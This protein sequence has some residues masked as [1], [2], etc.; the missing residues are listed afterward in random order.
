M[1]RNQLRQYRPGT[2][3]YVVL[4]AAWS[5]T[6]GRAPSATLPFEQNPRRALRR[7]ERLA[8]FPKNGTYLSGK[9]PQDYICGECGATG[10]K[11]WRNYQTFLEY[12][13]LRCLPCACREQD[14]IRTP[15]EDGRSLYAEEE[16]C[17]RTADM[18]PGC[19][20]FYDPKD[21][22][23]T[24]AIETTTHRTKTDQIGWRTPAV[25]TEEGGA[26]W[27]Y[28]SVPQPGCDWWASLPTITKGGDAP[29]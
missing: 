27:G 23:P 15:T 16:Y 21:G 1:N 22:P 18:E 2:A 11:L 25:P 13:T 12:Q 19:W 24:D 28:T 5:R 29:F 17:Y 8:Y 9:T 20:K 6:R 7:A 4:H 3:E 10:V 26:Y 14:K